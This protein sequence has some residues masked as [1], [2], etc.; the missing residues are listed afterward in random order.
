M[1]K[2]I[3]PGQPERPTGNMQTLLEDLQFCG[4]KCTQIVDIDANAGHW[5]RLA[6]SVFP[7]ADFCMI[8]PQ[9]E[10][11]PKLEALPKKYPKLQYHLAG[12]GL[13]EGSMVLT[14]WDDLLGSSSLLVADTKAIEMGKKCTVPI[15]TI[16][17]IW[18]LEK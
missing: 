17:V 11:L 13:D 3:S 10:M 8:E 14:V 18:R 2:T 15:I 16:D 7:N 12:A 6:Q 9:E 5:S 1:P 4:L